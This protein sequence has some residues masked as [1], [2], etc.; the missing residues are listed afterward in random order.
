MIKKNEFLGKKNTHS[1]LN[2]HMYVLRL[3]NHIK[4]TLNVW[5]EGKKSRYLINGIG[6]RKNIL[7]TYEMYKTEW[8]KSWFLIF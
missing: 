1:K 5:I 6:A 8:K 7:K 4:D 2:T 3:K